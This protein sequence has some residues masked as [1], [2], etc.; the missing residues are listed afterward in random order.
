MYLESTFQPKFKEGDYVIFKKGDWLDHIFIDN[1]K[2]KV[3]SYEHH[4]S[5]DYYKLEWTLPVGD[6]KVIDYYDSNHEKYLHFDLEK[7]RKD[8]I[9]EVLS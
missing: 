1:C 7:Y 8:K 5:G 9:D 2:A 6:T 4:N 3:I